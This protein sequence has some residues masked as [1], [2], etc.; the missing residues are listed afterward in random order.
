MLLLIGTLYLMSLLMFLAQHFAE[1][2]FRI[3]IYQ[4]GNVWLI[5]NLHQYLIP[6]YYLGMIYLGSNAR[7]I[8]GWMNLADSSQNMCH[9]AP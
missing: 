8:V 3:T 7:L 5:V 9:L 1:K 2:C 6:G 4:Y